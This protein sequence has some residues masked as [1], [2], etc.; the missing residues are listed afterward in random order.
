MLVDAHLG[1]YV[2]LCQLV[3]WELRTQSD[4]YLDDSCGIENRAPHILDGLSLF[5]TI[6]SKFEMK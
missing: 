1:L 4:K 2:I 5:S 6:L 3:Y